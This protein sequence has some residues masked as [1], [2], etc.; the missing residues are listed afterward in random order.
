MRILPITKLVVEK[1]KVYEKKYKNNNSR[2]LHNI[3]GGNMNYEL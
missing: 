1:A 2:F 3:Y